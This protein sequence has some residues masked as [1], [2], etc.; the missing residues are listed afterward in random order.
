[1]GAVAVASETQWNARIAAIAELGG[2]LGF[3]LQGEFISVGGGCSIEIDGINREHR[4]LCR[5]FMHIGNVQASQVEEVAS[6]ILKLLL[7]ERVLRGKWRKA[8]CF[9]DDSAARLLR[10]HS[11]WLGAAARA[12]KLEGFVVHL[13][14]EIRSALL[15]EQAHARGL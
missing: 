2:R 14:A 6:D 5:A 1:M 15:R 13:P 4:F 3:A 11:N 10:S 9:A 8:I 7:V 12:T